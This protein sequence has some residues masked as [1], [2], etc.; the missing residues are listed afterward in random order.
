MESGIGFFIGSNDT[1]TH[2]QGVI[3]IKAPVKISLDQLNLPSTGKIHTLDENKVFQ[4][5]VRPKKLSTIRNK[6][7]QDQMVLKDTTIHTGILSDH[8]LQQIAVVPKG[9]ELPSRPSNYHSTDWFTYIVFFSLLL[10]IIAKRT[11]EKYIPLLFRSITN[12]SLSSKLFREQNISFMQGSAIMEIFYLL[13]LG[14]FGFQVLKYFG[15]SLPFT[16]FISFFL[17][18]GMLIF[19]FLVKLLLYRLLGF[20][21][22]TLP[23]TNEY[24]FNMK[25]HNKVLGI[26]LFPVV[27]FSA[28]YPT[29]NPRLFMIT[30]LALIMVFYLIYLVRGMQILLKKHYS[31]FYLFLYLCTL[32]ILPLLLLI[33]I[34]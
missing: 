5:P 20:L 23:D 26:L 22:E 30:G 31:I 3:Q 10:F 34:I 28:W 4:Q 15:L 6:S 14:L 24:L 21:S 32:E 17:I 19:F 16:G 2:S 25:N 8:L 12:F 1:L 13:V 7:Q 33:R 11:S 27:G 18:L 9:I 29:Y